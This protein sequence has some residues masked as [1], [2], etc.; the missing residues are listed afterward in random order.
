M[1]RFLT[2]LILSIFIMITCI[3]CVSFNS[4]EFGVVHGQ[5]DMK[6][7]KIPVS[8]YTKV[9][10]DGGAE[11]IYSNKQLDYI[12]VYMQKN[13]L[14]EFYQSVSN[15]TLTIKWNK[16]IIADPNKI[17]KIYISNS[18]LKAININGSVK[19]SEAD[20]IKEKSFTLDVAGA[21]D[22]NISLDV[23]DFNTTISGA[24]RMNLSG[25]S[26]TASMK[27]NGAGQIDAINFQTNNSNITINGTGSAE[28]FCL[29]KLEANIAGAGS[30]RY[31]GDPSVSPSIVG[32]GSIKKVD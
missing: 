23:N 13:I 28:I 7:E 1:K 26:K 18:N 15:D 24:C 30:I 14:D 4:S 29:D 12:K 32:A 16:T 3:S 9:N 10:I 19:I 6:E 27:I 5:G 31:K 11:I 25:K 8:S 22:L 2:P 17:P 21:C 20:T